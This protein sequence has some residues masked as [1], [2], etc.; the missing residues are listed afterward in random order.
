MLPFAAVRRRTQEP[1]IAAEPRLASSAR[2]VVARAFRRP[3]VVFGIAAA[4]TALLSA[5]RLTKVP[6]Y[7]ATAYFRLVEGDVADPRGSSPRPPRL[8]R[9]Y[10]AAV[11]LSRQKLVEIMTEH[12]LYRKT[13]QRDMLQAV[14]SMR[15]DI[16]IDVTR[17]YFLYDRRPDDEPRSA[18][19]K[20]SYSSGDRDQARA[21][22][23]ELGQAVLDVQARQRTARLEAARTVTQAELTH[24]KENVRE[25]QG[26]L[27]QLWLD[28]AD[29]KGAE[30]VATNAQIASL[31]GSLQ[32]SV[33]RVQKLERKAAD[34]QLAS[35]IEDSRLGISFQ[36][37]DEEVVTR[38]PRLGKR[39][40]VRLVTAV[41]VSALLVTLVVV[42]AWGRRVY[43]AA[44]LLSVGVPVLGTL[45]RF[46]GDDVGPYRARIGKRRQ[47]LVQ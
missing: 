22:V 29:A 32:A 46:P 8:I 25:L 7:Q 10:V 12:N 6:S 20:I 30:L 35:A 38:A 26:Q 18:S 39:D 34:L 43:V 37:V 28:A 40:T 33:D 19:I 36:L 44:D 2:H 9:E 17:N 27:D 3:L 1:W 42:G 4:F 45:A 14:Q 47:R 5:Y 16:D 15:E 31:Q 41:F 21:I 13:R 24:V 11:A 23:H